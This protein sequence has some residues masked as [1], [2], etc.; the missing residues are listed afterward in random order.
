MERRRGIQFH[1]GIL[2]HPSACPHGGSQSSL[3]CWPAT[4]TAAF[5]CL[6]KNWRER[7]Q[8]EGGGV[9]GSIKMELLTENLSGL[10]WIVYSVWL[11]EIHALAG[12]QTTSEHMQSF[13]FSVQL[14]DFS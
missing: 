13:F 6:F 11:K 9:V 10:Q 14:G 12:E 7:I 1:G 4:T 8:I 5:R 3:L 2:S